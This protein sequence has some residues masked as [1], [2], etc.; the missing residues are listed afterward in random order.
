MGK[1]RIDTYAQD[2]SV[3]SLEAL[4]IGLEVFQLLLSAPGK[5]QGIKG[6]D[7]IFLAEKIL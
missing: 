1:N 3:F 2:L 6:Q 7:D 5:I 4:A